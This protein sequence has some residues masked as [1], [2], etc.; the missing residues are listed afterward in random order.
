MVVSVDFNLVINTKIQRTLANILTSIFKFQEKNPDN[1]SGSGGQPPK[2]TKKPASE[3]GGPPSDQLSQ[4]SLSG[5][6]GPKPK[7]QD[8]SKTQSQESLA[9]TSGQ[10]QGK[11]QQQQQQKKQQ[12]KPMSSGVRGPEQQQQAPQLQG[13]WAA[14]PQQQQ[15]KQAQLQKK[16]EPPKSQQQHQPP[17]ASG[18]RQQQAAPRNVQQKPASQA[19]P[20]AAPH[21]IC[22]YKGPGGKGK[23]VDGL[24]ANYLKLDISKLVQVAYHYDV[25]IAPEVPKK[26]LPL[27]FTAFCRKNF[28]NTQIAFDGRKN[29]YAPCRLDLE[30]REIVNAVEIV[31]AETGN[32]RKYTV[33]IQEANDSAIS[34]GWLKKYVRSFI[35]DIILFT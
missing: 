30:K 18:S 2:E 21:L 32:T 35:F 1:P 16:P 4:M 29:A 31:D 7:T 17:M 6:Q 28:G 20:T 15:P 9:S 12:P 23:K 25:T 14:Q 11:R 5:Q 3:K 26:K 22:E 33:H 24:E 19:I 34:M 10:S 27:A 8:K 13:S